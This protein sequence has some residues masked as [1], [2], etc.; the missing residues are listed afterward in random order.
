MAVISY[1]LQRTNPFLSLCCSHFIGFSN[2]KI[3]Y[4]LPLLFPSGFASFY[5]YHPQL[6]SLHYILTIL[7]LVITHERMLKTI[8]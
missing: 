8:I 7:V 1:N 6:A 3:Q 4:Q 5:H 2:V